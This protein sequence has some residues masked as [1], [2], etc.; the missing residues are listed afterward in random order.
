[1]LIQPTI[2]WRTLSK[3][4]SDLAETIKPGK[5]LKVKRLGYL[6]FENPEEV[7]LSFNGISLAHVWMPGKFDDSLLKTDTYVMFIEEIN[8]EPYAHSKFQAY[9][10]IYNASNKEV[11]KLFKVIYMNRIGYIH[12]N[13]LEE[14]DDAYIAGILQPQQ[15]NPI[16]LPGI[17]INTAPSIPQPLIYTPDWTVYPTISY[18]I[19][20]I[21]FPDEVK[22]TCVDVFNKSKE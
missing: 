9:T 1:M 16:Q 21:I 22:I 11:T 20:D 15:L 10:V 17:G 3:M 4:T 5:L 13:A 18:P 2:F 8:I 7:H 6:L 19:T 12:P 14:A